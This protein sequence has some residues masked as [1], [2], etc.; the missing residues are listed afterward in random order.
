M[1]RVEYGVLVLTLVV[2]TTTWWFG[3]PGSWGI[4]TLRIDNYVHPSERTTLYL[5]LILYLGHEI[6]RVI[7]RNL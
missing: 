2:I 6:Y 1:R 7:R 3:C 5:V 4:G